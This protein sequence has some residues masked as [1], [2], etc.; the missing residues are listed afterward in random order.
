M[1]AYVLYDNVFNQLGATLSYSH[2][3]DSS[4]PF[5]HDNLLYDKWVHGQSSGTPYIQT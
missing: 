5:A 4:G 2:E 3:I 1:T